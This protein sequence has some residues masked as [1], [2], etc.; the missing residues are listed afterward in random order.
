MAECLVYS[1]NSQT[2]VSYAREMSLLTNSIV[3]IKKFPIVRQEVLTVIH[4]KE[5]FSPNLP[6]GNAVNIQCFGD[7]SS[8]L[9]IKT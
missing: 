2:L 6:R 7:C 5:A 3:L 4:C 8:T 9:M 1:S